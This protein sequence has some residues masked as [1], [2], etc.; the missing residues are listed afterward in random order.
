MMFRFASIALSLALAT[1]AL[2]PALAQHQAAP[3][4]AAATGAEVSAGDLTISGGFTRATL[5]GAPVAGGFLTIT[6]SGTEDDRLVA[7]T[8]SIA[9]EAQIHEMAL[10]NEI[11]KMRRLEDGLVIPAGETVTLAPGGYHLM[12]MGLTGAIAEGDAVAVTLTF[13]RGGDVAIDLVA[14]PADAK[15]SH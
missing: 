5:P 3:A 8:T 12:F 1:S 14:G 11:M 2:T 13:E 15:K 9:K 6:N 10:E 7:V 4:M